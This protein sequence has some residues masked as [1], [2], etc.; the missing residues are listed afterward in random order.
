MNFLYEIFTY[1]LLH[2]NNNKLKHNIRSFFE[3]NSFIF[4]FHFYLLIRN[5]IFQLDYILSRI[6]YRLPAS[7][8]SRECSIEFRFSNFIGST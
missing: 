7:R 8:F 4:Q 3:K 5:E 1:K 2:Q 6:V